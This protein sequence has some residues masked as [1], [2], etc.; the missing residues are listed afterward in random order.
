MQQRIID[1]LAQ[2]FGEKALAPLEVHVQNWSDEEYIR[3]GPVANF[4]TGVLSQV[5]DISEPE[6]RIHWAGTE[7]ANGG[8]GYMD[9][10][11]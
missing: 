1:K 5:G 9:G 8:Q 3:G 2:F 11:I 4:P 10:A 7:M 6:G